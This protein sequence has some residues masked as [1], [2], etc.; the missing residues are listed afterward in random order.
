MRSVAAMALSCLTTALWAQQPSEPIV[1]TVNQDGTVTSALKTLTDPTTVNA[2]STYGNT[3][4]NII[5]AKANRRN[6]TANV[7]DT[8][9]GEGLRT[10]GSIGQGAAAAPFNALGSIGQG[11]PAA[12]ATA[13]GTIGSGAFEGSV[14]SGLNLLNSVVVKGAEGIGVLYNDLKNLNL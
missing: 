6:A 14:A 9:V 5:N 3:R 10:V 8:T 4:A 11:T 7:L 1:L 12:M 13:V 2:V